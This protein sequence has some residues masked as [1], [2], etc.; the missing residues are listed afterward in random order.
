MSVLPGLSY[1]TLKW[2]FTT[3]LGVIIMLS[4]IYI[5]FFIGLWTNKYC[6]LTYFSIVV[7]SFLLWFNSMT[8]ATS[9]RKFMRGS[10]LQSTLS[11]FPPWHGTLQK[12][13]RHGTWMPF[14]SNTSSYL[15]DSQTASRIRYNRNIRYFSAHYFCS[16]SNICW[17]VLI[18]RF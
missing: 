15:K 14:C 18:L 5:L 1:T 16:A 11:P 3:I 6:C 8:K 10:Q 7:Y 4:Q 9:I 2:K 12:A 17:I 13:G